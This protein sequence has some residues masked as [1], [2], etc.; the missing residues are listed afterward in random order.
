MESLFDQGIVLNSK[1]TKKEQTKC[2][3]SIPK[4]KA[5]QESKLIV[6]GAEL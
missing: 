1:Q 3:E 4:Q 2:Q 5:E 6:V